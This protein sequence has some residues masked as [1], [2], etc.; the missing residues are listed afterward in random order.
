MLPFRNFAVHCG[1]LRRL[2]SRL[3]ADRRGGKSGQRRAPHHL[4]GGI[5]MKIGGQRV[6]QK[7]TAFWSRRVGEVGK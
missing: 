2:E 1:L 6:S 5:L 7:I 4:T 3:R